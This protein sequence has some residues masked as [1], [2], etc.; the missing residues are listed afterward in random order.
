MFNYLKSSSLA[1]SYQHQFHINRSLIWKVIITNW[2]GFKFF[3]YFLNLPRLGPR[4]SQSMGVHAGNDV[5]Q[6]LHCIIRSEMFRVVMFSPEHSFFFQIHYIPVPLFFIILEIEL[7][8]SQQ[9]EHTEISK[10]DS[11]QRL[12]A[13]LGLWLNDG[14]C[15]LW[16][17][18]SKCVNFEF[19]FQSALIWP[20]FEKKNQKQILHDSLYFACLKIS[21][22]IG[23]ILIYFENELIS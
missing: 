3:N 11:L 19:F 15:S 6:A 16:K 18:K 14:R 17:K 21:K 20:I 1:T 12:K 22:I 7:Y 10:T 9:W 5:I 2:Q 23:L 8:F 4:S 13:A